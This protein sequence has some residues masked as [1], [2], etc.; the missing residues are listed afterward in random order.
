MMKTITIKILYYILCIIFFIP[1]IIT[2]GWLYIK[3]RL[4]DYIE[5]IQQK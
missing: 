5:W 1:S 3:D 2:F 4:E